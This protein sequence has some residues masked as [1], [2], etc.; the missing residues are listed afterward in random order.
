MKMLSCLLLLLPFCLLSRSRLRAPA[1]LLAAASLFVLFGSPAYFPHYS[2][3]FLAPLL[4]A[5]V[6]VAESARR[7]P[8]V[9]L[10]LLL[11]LSPIFYIVPHAGGFEAARAAKLGREFRQPLLVVPARGELPKEPPVRVHCA[12]ESSS[13]FDVTAFKPSDDGKAWILRIF[14][15]TDKTRQ[16]AVAWSQPAP[17]AVFL[18][19]NTE[20]PLGPAG[21][22][23]DVPALTFVTLRAELP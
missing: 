16:A 7:K 13:P 10:L 17:K 22:K 3:I 9:T 4:F 12:G 23:V 1:F 19:D 11:A 18:S 21:E 15:P 6:A 14:N 5:A 20:R 8:A 2:L